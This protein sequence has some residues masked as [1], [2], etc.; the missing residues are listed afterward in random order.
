MIKMKTGLFSLPVVLFPHSVLPLH[1]FEERYKELISDCLEKDLQFGIN[2]LLRSE[3]QKKGCTARIIDV[4]KKYDD[5]RYDIVVEGVRRYRILQTED[6]HG[7]YCRGYIE[8]F[9]D[10]DEVPD[11]DLAAQAAGLY[12]EMADGLQGL[13][14]DKITPGVTGDNLLSFFM[15]QKAGLTLEQRQRLLESDSENERLGY[16]VEHMRKISPLMDEALQIQK[17]MMNDGYLKPKF[18]K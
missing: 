7:S 12:N 3:M 4:L 2:L 11:E 6:V 5:G 15:A 18:L 17:I 16:I 14:L 9:D 8:F 13:N 10:R 1:I